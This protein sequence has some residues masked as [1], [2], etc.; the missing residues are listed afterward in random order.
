M[1]RVASSI[2][3]VDF[4]GISDT[5]IRSK[6]AYLINCIKTP[7]SAIKHETLQY[8]DEPSYL[9]EL[10]KCQLRKNSCVE[11]LMNSAKSFRIEEDYIT[12]S[13]VESKKHADKKQ[14]LREVK[15]NNAIL[16]ACED[17][18]SVETPISITDMFTHCENQL[19]Q[20]LITGCAGIGKT[21]FCRYVAYQWASGVLWQEYDLAI[22]LNFRSLTDTRYPVLPF[23]KKYSL[24]DVVIIE[25]FSNDLNENEKKLLEKQMNTTNVLWL[26]D[27]YD[28][29]PQNV[30]QHLKYLFDQLL[31]TP[32][33][34][35]TSRSYLNTQSYSVQMEIIGFTNE[36]ISK[37][38]QSFCEQHQLY[39]TDSSSTSRKCHDFLKNNPRIWG[40]SHIPVY[41]ELICSV[42]RDIVWNQNETLTITNLYSKIIN[43]LCLRYLQRR[44]F[45]IELCDREV[46]DKCRPELIFF[47]TLAFK[48]ME[49]N[50]TI[51]PP[52]L[53]Q[54]VSTDADIS[55]KDH[56]D[57]LSM[58]FVRHLDQGPFGIHRQSDQQHYFVHPSF[59]EYLTSQYLIRILC[60][61]QPQLAID[62]IRSQKYNQ[63]FH[64]V[65]T[66][67]SGLL[68]ERNDQKSLNLLWDILLKKPIDFIGLRHLQILIACFNES[69]CNSHIP[70]RI[71]VIN[72]IIQWIKY[73]ASKNVPFLWET[74]TNAMKSCYCLTVQNW[75]QETLC[76]LLQLDDYTVVSNILDFISTLPIRSP[77][78]RLVTSIAAYLRTS[79][80]IISNQVL[81]RLHNT[82]TTRETDDYSIPGISSISSSYIVKQAACV[83]LLHI[84]QMTV[85]SEAIFAFL[86]A[87][88]DGNSDVRRS[89][90]QAL[91]EMGEK[92]ATSSVI[93]ALLTAMDDEDY[94][95]RRSACQAVGEMGKA[96]VT[97][98]VIHGLLTRVNDKD[99]SVQRQAFEAL[100]KM[101]EK[102]VTSEFIYGLLMAMNNGD[103]SIRRSACETLGNLGTKVETH[104]VIRELL[105]AMYDDDSSM[106]CTVCQAVGAIGE[107]LATD[108]IIRALLTAMDDQNNTVRQLACE[109]LSKLGD[110]AATS[111]VTHK[112]LCATRDKDP[113][114]RSSACEALVQIGGKSEINEI[115]HAL[116]RA[117]SDVDDC[118]QNDA[119]EALTEMSE[120]VGITGVINVLLT[121]IGDADISMRC[122]ACKAVGA[123]G[124]TLAT[125]KVIRALVTAMDDHNNIVRKCA[126]KALGNLGEKAITKKVIK[127]LLAAMSDEDILMR[128]TACEVAGVIGGTAATGQVIRALLDRMSDQNNIVRQCA[129]KA[130]GRI[131]DK[132]VTDEIINGLLTSMAD[133]D[134]LIRQLTCEILGKIGE[135]AAT[136]KVVGGL[137]I[138]MSD[139]DSTTRQ[140]AYEALVRMCE[141]AVTSEAILGLLIAMKDE[142]ILRQRNAYKVAGT[143]G[144]KTATRQIIDVLLMQL[145][146]EQ[147]SKV[148]LRVCKALCRMGEKAANKEVI[149]GLISAMNDENILIRYHACEAI[150]A[151]GERAATDKVIHELLVR[152]N[153]GD[154]R[155]CQLACEAL[156]RMGEKAATSEVISGLLTAM[157][158][159]DIFLRLRVYEVVGAMGRK[160]TAREVIHEFL[161]KMNGED[162]KLGERAFEVLGRMGEK[163]ATDKIINGLLIAMNYEDIL[164]RYRACEVVGTLG[165]AIATD[166]LI[167][168]LLTRMNDQDRKMRQYVCEALGR[169]G[170]KAATKEVIR[171]LLIGMNDEFDIVRT[172][173]CKALS[174]I[175]ENAATSFICSGMADLLC[176]SIGCDRLVVLESIEELVSRLLAR[177]LKDGLLGGGCKSSDST[178]CVD[179]N[180][181]LCEKLLY[182]YC[183]TGDGNWLKSF[184]CVMVFENNAFV[185]E[186]S[187]CGIIGTTT[188]KWFDVKDRRLLV[189]M[190]KRFGELRVNWDSGTVNK[191]I[192]TDE[193]RIRSAVEKDWLLSVIDIIL[194]SVLY[195]YMCK[196]ICICIFLFL[197]LLY[198]YY[199]LDHCIF[200]MT[201]SFIVSFL[202]YCTI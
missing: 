109:A 70:N 200:K 150:G 182:L 4:Q 72:F 202:L 13:I 185:L 137:L 77:S 111:S 168:T 166:E 120:K 9:F 19:R 94:L 116:L 83:A 18:N 191:N 114:V 170:G 14:K 34:I 1:A 169:M 36:G 167:G 89:A 154:R 139:Q 134:I 27:G 54:S 147:D 189:R 197:F 61:T 46:Y 96:A 133:E 121:T 126:C 148:R 198:I 53:L 16:R 164:M 97:T 2:E 91:G 142:N 158:H 113:L 55:F 90:C 22:L 177:R 186:G 92:A 144:Q 195:I 23:G 84:S 98:E 45:P 157:N 5:N 3:H 172:S 99:G 78:V 35:M 138:R 153:D 103:I 106:R 47:Q 44:N 62:F 75:L 190:K 87:M 49:R 107:I 127:R 8:N 86:A 101:R 149:N 76:D 95:V 52:E 38:V 26:L 159:E 6:V 140:R 122:N 69:N 143:I 110:K 82:I 29:I 17:I 123:I 135:K 130:L 42:W 199:S 117:I 178:M 66:F 104:L 194:E 181:S 58:G 136:T 40:I 59:S 93:C 152:M 79:V 80:P 141:K 163:I 102:A 174:R 115:I 176:S 180:G 201:F 128:C 192:C 146:N 15:N 155:V 183:Q 43:W 118:V 64:F 151:M 32:H 119:I 131:G 188:S 25:Y 171:V 7:L 74:L 129:C 161:N 81:S 100:D 187:R 37:Y 67:M 51:I 30:S 179:E 73:T 71:H 63:R 20:I 132:T 184:V 56:P 33:H 196:H 160:E 31:R 21:T 68:H 11:R 173:A 145:N 48:A 112:I 24:T 12:P 125:N 165:E 156:G 39:I 124:K 28:E 105:I 57:L 50:S 175:G 162:R 10:I 65:C 193:K 60:S 88:N 41:L 108:E 85:S